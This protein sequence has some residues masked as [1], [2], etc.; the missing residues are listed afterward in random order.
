MFLKINTKAKNI[1]E[2]D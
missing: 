1:I 2:I